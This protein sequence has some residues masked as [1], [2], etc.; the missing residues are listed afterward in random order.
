MPTEER[1]AEMIDA[2]AEYIKGTATAEQRAMLLTTD[3]TGGSVKVSNIVDDFI[4][5][6]WDKSP[7][8]SRIRKVYVQGNYS[9]GYCNR[10]FHPNSNGEEV[11]A[12][13]YT[14]SHMCNPESFY[15]GMVYAGK[16][17]GGFNIVFWKFID[18]SNDN[19]LLPK[20]HNVDGACGYIYSLFDYS[21]RQSEERKNSFGDC[22]GIC[23]CWKQY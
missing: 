23:Y 2:L 10:W 5:T 1:K 15:D 8:L 22:C 3:A 4:W 7:I 21:C 13:I 12:G 20:L 6:D 18:L 11:L 19:Q 16:I 17:V 9:V 14:M